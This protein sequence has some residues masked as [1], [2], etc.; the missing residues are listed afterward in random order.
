MVIKTLL[1]KKRTGPNGFT[2]G[3]YQTFKEWIQILQNLLKYRQGRRTSQLI[4]EGQYYLISKADKD[5]TRNYILINISY[6]YQCENPQKNVESEAYPQNAWLVQHTK[7]NHSNT[8][9]GRLQNK[10][11]IIIPI[12]PEKASDKIQH[13]LMILL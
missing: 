9:T 6:E 8:P 7:I 10:H 2:G 13:P 1:T 5:I 12:Y 3:F 11:H 4:Q